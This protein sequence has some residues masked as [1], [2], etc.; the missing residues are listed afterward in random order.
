MYLVVA[1]FEVLWVAEKRGKEK[2]KRGKEKEKKKKK[3][4]RKKERK[5]SQIMYSNLTLSSGFWSMPGTQ[6]E[7]NVTSS[8]TAF[9]ENQYI[10]VQI[11]HSPPN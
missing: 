1:N 4:R 6:L 8:C 3:K 7:A 11:G 5:L 10:I 9:S 2:E